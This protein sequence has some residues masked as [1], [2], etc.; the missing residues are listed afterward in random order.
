VLPALFL[1]LLPGRLD[2][3]AP[4][5]RIVTQTTTVETIAPGVDSGEYDFDT[6][7]GPIVV[8]VIAVAPHR[9]DVAV[10]NVLANDALASPGET[11]SSMAVRTGAVAG[12]NGDYFD[13][14]NTNAPTNIVAVDG[15]LVRTPR[16]R[17]ALLV[18]DDGSSQIVE[19]SFLGQVTFPDR[20]VALDALN[21]FP[22]PNRGISLLTPAFGSVPPLVNLT[23]VAL[24]P[25]GGALPFA[26]YTVASIADNLTRQKPGY[27]LA[28]GDD[29]YTLTGVPNAGDALSVSG[30]L[31]PVPLDTIAAAIGGGPLILDGGAWADDPD[32]PSGGEYGQRIPSSGAA[33][34]SDGTLYLLEIDGRQPDVSV[35]VTRPEFAAIM[36]ALGASRGMAFDGGGSSALAQR[37]PGTPAAALASSPSDGIERRV[38]DGVFVYSTAPVGPAARIVVNPG[39]VRAVV[40]ARL[41]VHAAAIDIS[42]HLVNAPEPIA[43]AV[44]PARIGEVRDG[45]FTALANGDGWI[46]AHAGVLITRVPIRVTDDPARVEIVP[47]HPFAER[48]ATIVLHARAYDATGAQLTLPPSLAWRAVNGTIDASGK[49]ATTDRDALVSLLIGNHLA[50]ATVIVGSHDVEAAGVSDAR[51]LSVPRGGDGDVT[52][53]PDCPACLLLRYSLGPSERAAYALLLSPLPPNSIAVAFDVLD[54][55][56]GARIRLAL[57]NAINEDVLLAGTTLDHPGWRHVIVRLPAGLAQPARLTGIYVIGANGSALVAGTIEIK[58]VTVSVAGPR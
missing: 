25:N 57:R 46:T 45:E 6:A 54:D 29:A 8:R 4:F 37:A 15:A 53:P 49:L 56:N 3:P 43:I 32:G 35:G 27:Y 38:A 22:P 20:T 36:R 24:E 26:H 34:A 33:I 28:I 55:G 42:E 58:N 5:P 18:L 16:K 9:N 14:G 52:H 50:D 17:Y 48:N 44:D 47:S 10:Q 40:G 7:E 41:P 51:F 31:S 2:P 30:D 23:L 12:I 21:E 1:A 19:S 39:V 13:I 11:V